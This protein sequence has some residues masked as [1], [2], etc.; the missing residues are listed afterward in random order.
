MDA[1]WIKSKTQDKKRL[2]EAVKRP[3]QDRVVQ[4]PTKYNYG[5]TASMSTIH[6]TGHH[7]K[8][9][10]DETATMEGL[11]NSTNQSTLSP[12]NTSAGRSTNN[13]ARTS[14]SSLGGGGTIG[15]DMADLAQEHFDEMQIGGSVG[16]E[17]E[18]EAASLGSTIDGGKQL[19]GK[20]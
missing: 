1:S 13:E 7:K 14:N 20:M 2:A 8:R 5:V 10:S 12:S 17:T 3:P 15:E 11:T 9:R 6:G 18:K 19:P 4:D 16:A